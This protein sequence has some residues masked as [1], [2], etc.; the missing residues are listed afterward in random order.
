MGK[1][2]LVIG[3]YEGKNRLYFLD[4]HFPRGWSDAQKNRLLGR[5]QYL[6]EIACMVHVHDNNAGTIDVKE[7]TTGAD[8]RKE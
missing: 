8:S 6:K 2:N 1:K 4:P 3:S 5:V 7:Q